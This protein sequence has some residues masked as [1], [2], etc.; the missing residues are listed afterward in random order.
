MHQNENRINQ[1]RRTPLRAGVGRR[2]VR[3]GLLATASLTAVSAAAVSAQ[4]AGPANHSTNSRGVAV[5]DDSA[6]ALANP[7]HETRFDDSFTVHQYGPL[8]AAG[9]R[10]QAQAES[11]SCSAGD[12]CRSVALSFQIVTM[13]GENI[14]LNA[15]NL[16]HASNVHCAGCQTLSAAYQFVVSTPNAFTLSASAQAQLAQIHRKLDALGKS[17]T[18]VDTVRQQADALAAQ[19]VT[20][21][22]AAAATAPKG[23]G[24]QAQDSMAP[25]VTMQRMDS[26]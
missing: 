4:A 10:N 26:F 8:I 25:T 16:S 22:R 21:L 19:V 9:L 11:V 18:P 5:A 12:P 13:A 2:A 17:T 1:H 7:G 20:V 23:P 6:H 3:F 14:H 15:V 24:V